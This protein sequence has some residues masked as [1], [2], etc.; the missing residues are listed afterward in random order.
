MTV[1]QKE[2]NEAFHKAVEQKVAEL[3]ASKQIASNSDL[4]NAYSDQ[5]ADEMYLKGV[6][7]EE[8]ATYTAMSLVRQPL[9]SEIQ[10]LTVKRREVTDPT[11][12]QQID[13]TLAADKRK[14]NDIMGMQCFNES[15]TR[16]K[17]LTEG[18]EAPSLMCWGRG[19]GEH[20]NPMDT[21]VISR[22]NSLVTRNDPYTGNLN[23]VLARIQEFDNRNAS[24]YSVDPNPELDKYVDTVFVGDMG[25]EAFTINGENPYRVLDKI[26]AG[27]DVDLGPVH[28]T[29]VMPRQMDVSTENTPDVDPGYVETFDEIFSL[30]N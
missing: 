13:E 18:V 3:H 6:S 22:F 5:V 14:Y 19:Y 28:G 23:P 12:R 29:A 30:G 27:E 8:A 16:S 21:S 24:K 2:W 17:T 15:E 25:P 11:Q 7:P 10:S 1:H 26:R 4:Q 20:S 9:L